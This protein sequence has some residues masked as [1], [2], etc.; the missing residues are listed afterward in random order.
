MN[1]LTRNVPCLDRFCRTTEPREWIVLERRHST[2][3]KETKQP[4]WLPCDNFHLASRDKVTKI[5]ITQR[6][7][8]H[9][10]SRP[11]F[12]ALAD[13]AHDK[14]ST[15]PTTTTTTPFHPT[16]LK[17]EHSPLIKKPNKYNRADIYTFNTCQFQ[18][19]YSFSIVYSVACFCK[20]W[21]K[22]IWFF[23]NS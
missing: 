17:I 3:C 2:Y 10:H 12:S 7:V 5:T 6:S 4:T 16:P 9:W 21:N 18:T 1:D 20:L 8:F 15:T 13:T 14:T 22:W 23:F 19:E 11:Q